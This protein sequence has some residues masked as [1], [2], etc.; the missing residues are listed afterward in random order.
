MVRSA[1]YY[2]DAP[3]EWWGVAFIQA[4]LIYNRTPNSAIANDTPFRRWTGK[5]ADL[6][7]F[8]TLFAPVEVLIPKA[9]RVSKAH[10]IMQH[11]INFGLD[12]DTLD[13]YLVYLPSKKLVI[14]SRD[15]VFDEGWQL[16]A[17]LR[18]NPSIAS[19]DSSGIDPPLVHWN[20]SD[21]VDLRSCFRDKSLLRP[22]TNSVTFDL[23]DN[24]STPVPDT[25]ALEPSPS[26]MS[27]DF[28][29]CSKYDRTTPIFK[30][31]TAA[32]DTFPLDRIVSHMPLDATR[33]TAAVRYEIHWTDN[34]RITQE[35]INAR[36]S[37]KPTPWQVNLKT[38]NSDGTFSV[39]WK[40][41]H[42]PA[43]VL[44]KA[45]LDEYWKT[46]RSAS[47]QIPEVN[48]ITSKNV[49][50]KPPRRSPRTSAFDRSALPALSSRVFTVF[51]HH[52]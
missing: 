28:D 2:A 14:T 27:P 23:P 50:I 52:S 12:P 3:I 15:V 26:S 38:P 40:N 41:T 48:K 44:K 36:L 22:S 25:S 34:L 49:V 20:K 51:T 17:Q 18:L 42:E 32:T 8:R 11:G 33:G 4:I 13:G 21:S 29:T 6:S 30:L 37:A 16:R 45:H 43:T 39:V 5:T 46:V 19:A 47:A 31:V 9:S 10:P 35:A 24:I 1:L 7:L